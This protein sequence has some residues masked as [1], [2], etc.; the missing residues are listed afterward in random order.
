MGHFNLQT[1]M[2]LKISPVLACFSIVIF[3]TNNLFCLIVSHIVE[4][5]LNCFKMP[6]FIP[7]LYYPCPSASLLACPP[8]FGL[9]ATST[10]HLALHCGMSGVD[11][12]TVLLG[13]RRLL[14]SPHHRVCLS[15][16]IMEHW[17]MLWSI[18]YIKLNLRSLIYI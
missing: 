11:C 14:K 10:L 2:L 1:K 9:V 16:T 6:S 18:R 7:Q 4:I 8:L 12:S 3:P 5:V 15:G 13:G 17:K